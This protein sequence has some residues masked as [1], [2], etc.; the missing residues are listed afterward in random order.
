[1]RPGAFRN[2]RASARGAVHGRAFPLAA[3]PAGRRRASAAV[4]PGCAGTGVAERPANLTPGAAMDILPAALAAPPTEPAMAGTSVAGIGAFAAL[5]GQAIAAGAAPEEEA[6]EAPLPVAAEVIVEPQVAVPPESLPGLLPGTGAGTAI[7][8]AGG[9]LGLLAAIAPPAADVVGAP[10]DEPPGDVPQAPTLEAP[11]AAI[12]APVQAAM[13]G[14]A[15][16]AI[17][18]PIAPPAPPPPGLL[19]AAAPAPSPPAAGPAPAAADAAPLAAGPVP[20]AANLAAAEAAPRAADAAPVATSLAPVTPG[21]AP[22]AADAAPRAGE[23]APEP[24]MPAAPPPLAPPPAAAP[25][26]GVAPAIAVPP[27]SPEVAMPATPQAGAIA[28]PSPPAADPP[29]P[30]ATLVPL[31][32]PAPEAQAAPPPVPT[33]RDTGE[34]T[35]LALAVTQQAAAQPAPR[36]PARPAPVMPDAA[37]PTPMPPAGEAMPPIEGD[38]VADQA[39]LADPAIP[40]AADAEPMPADAVPLAESLLLDT[41]APDARGRA[42]ASRPVAETPSAAAEPLPALTLDPAPRTPPVAASLATRPAGAAAFA[43]PARQVAPFAVAL[44]LGPDSSLTLTLDPA[45]LG[46]VEVAIE[47]SQGEAS[48]RVTAERADTLMLLQRDAREL[49]RALADIGMGERGP[50][51]SFSLGDGGANRDA[52]GRQGDRA[53]GQAPRLGLAG[54]TGLP[55]AA[56]VARQGAAHRG[57]LDLAV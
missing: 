34:P 20:V 43:W 26:T 22:P 18:A 46:R 33:R 55:L 44:A 10:A 50:S 54:A 37:A 7:D 48:I 35:T 3:D 2:A 40:H 15:P 27:A 45:E 16:P 13:P 57:L 51:L 47:R 21:A 28:G 52:P 1:M 5:L 6:A 23:A 11:P 42:D 49:E 12:P 53:G 8:M 29:G 56:A 25:P 39:P 19:P 9:F 4:A 36:P 24:A 38:L 14:P 31:R 32:D 17:P 41:P 30:A